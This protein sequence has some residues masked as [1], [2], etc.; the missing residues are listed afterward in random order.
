MPFFSTILSHVIFS[1]F[2]E[3]SLKTSKKFFIGFFEAV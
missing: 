1:C 3:V 2:C